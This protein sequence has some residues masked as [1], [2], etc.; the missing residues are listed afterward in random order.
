MIHRYIKA[1]VS[2]FSIAWWGVSGAILN[3]QFELVFEFLEFLAS[4][5]AVGKVGK[6]A[7]PARTGCLARVANPI[8]F[9]PV[10]FCLGFF[11]GCKLVTLAKDFVVFLVFFCC[12]LLNLKLKNR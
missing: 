11:L 2:D 12:F 10:F 6:V 5:E 3:I 8:V 9:L 4:W 1:G 7:R